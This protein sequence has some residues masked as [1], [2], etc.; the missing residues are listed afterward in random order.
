MMNKTENTTVRNAMTEMKIEENTEVV[1]EVYSDA[2]NDHLRVALDDWGNIER[3]MSESS[4]IDL[5]AARGYELVDYGNSGHNTR[6][7]N[8]N[9]KHLCTNCD[10]QAMYDTKQ[11]AFYCPRCESQ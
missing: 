10:S 4:L 7:V 8:E 2:W 6:I 5:I 11:N 9:T 3:K 1:G